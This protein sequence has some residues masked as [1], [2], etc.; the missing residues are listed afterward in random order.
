ME[1]LFFF[2]CVAATGGIGWSICTLLTGRS[3]GRAGLIETAALSYLFGFGSVSI[4]MFVLGLFGIGF[5]RLT[6]LLPWTPVVV[7]AGV[8]AFLRRDVTGAVKRE[9]GEPLT[10]RE[11]A[12]F[13]LIAMQTCYNFFRAVIKPVEAYDAVAIYGLKSKILYLAGGLPAGFFEDVS[14]G[15]HGAHADYPLLVPLCETWVY[16]FLGRI[17]DIIVKM[18]FPLFFLALLCVFYSVLRKVLQK[19]V[20][21][22]LFTFFLASIKQLS[23]YATISVADMVLG[24]YYGVSVLFLF[25][26][27]VRGREARYLWISLGATVFCIWTKNEGSLL[28][29][30]NIALLIVSFVSARLF[31][32]GMPYGGK[33]IRRILTYCLVIVVVA[34]GWAGCKAYHGLVNENFN[35]SMVTF[36]NLISSA[37]KIP[38]ILYGYQKEFFGLKKWNIFWILLLG[39]FCVRSRAFFSREAR[40]LTGALLLFGASYFLMYLFSVVEVRYFVR[41]TASRFLLHILPVAVFLLAVIAKKEALLDSV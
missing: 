6:V 19:R 36:R 35:V 1:V 34:G 38:A 33:E 30:V 40:W 15:F 22:L 32:E 21:C 16:T 9:R 14:S 18:L 26:W 13:I 41:F 27:I 20:H 3:A 4:W 5:T 12:L 17:D 37:E 28:A 24:I 2:L 11:T 25:L 29:A 8:Y 31:K 39:L 23:D 10:V 7:T